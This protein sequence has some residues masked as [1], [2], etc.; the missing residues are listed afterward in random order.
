MVVFVALG[1]SPSATRRLST[2]SPSSVVGAQTVS[3]QY[4]ERY[5]VTDDE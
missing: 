1:G 2:G 4:D 3:K 5:G